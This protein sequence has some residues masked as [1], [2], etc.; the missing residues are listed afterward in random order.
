MEFYVNF[1]EEVINVNGERLSRTSAYVSI[2]DNSSDIIKSIGFD[3][4]Q[5][6]KE[7]ATEINSEDW[8]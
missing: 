5:E 4:E 2:E 6:A 1:Y 8:R 7:Y 3:N